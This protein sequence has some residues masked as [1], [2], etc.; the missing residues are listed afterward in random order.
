MKS[1]S[2]LVNQLRRRGDPQQSVNGA[3]QLVAKFSRLYAEASPDDQFALPV[4]M[5]NIILGRK[6]GSVNMLQARRCEKRMIEA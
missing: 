4:W 5:R 1:H 2:D 6:K 3:K